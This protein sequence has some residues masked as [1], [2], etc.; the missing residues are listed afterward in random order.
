MKD[1]NLSKLIDEIAS[2][3]KLG[4]VLIIDFPNKIIEVTTL[5]NEIISIIKTSSASVSIS[6]KSIK[7]IINQ[8][9]EGAEYIL[10]SI[11]N[12]L[13]NPS[14]IASNSHKRPDS[15]LFAKMNGSAKGVV[16]EI[17]KTT[18]QNMVVSAFPI[19]RK[20][21]RKMIDISGRAAVP[22]FATPTD[23]EKSS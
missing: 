9:K 19:D 17:T 1:R 6:R 7:H 18:T 16:L 15:F 22:P 11:P 3:K 14:K 5:S 10:L 12:I 13:N 20:T 8:R 4:D 2:L 21:Y 23:S